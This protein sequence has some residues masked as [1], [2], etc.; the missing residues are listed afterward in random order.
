M[1]EESRIQHFIYSVVGNE[2]VCISSDTLSFLQAISVVDG[3]F[4]YVVYHKHIV[5]S[6]CS[7]Y[8]SQGVSQTYPEM[9][10]ST[11]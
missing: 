8:L 7:V 6:V 4:N 11:N 10:F 3:D 5:M 2:E 9:G 1:A